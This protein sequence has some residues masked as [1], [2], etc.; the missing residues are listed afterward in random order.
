[1]HAVTDNIVFAQ[2]PVIV[3]QLAIAEWINLPDI[4]GHEDGVY[5][6]LVCIGVGISLV[7]DNLEGIGVLSLAQRYTIGRVAYGASRMTV[8]SP[9]FLCLTQM[10]GDSV[11]AACSKERERYLS[12]CGL[13][14]VNEIN[15]VFMGY[16]DGGFVGFLQWI[17]C[18]GIGKGGGC[19]E[20]LWLG[21]R[22]YL[23]VVVPYPHTPPIALSRL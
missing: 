5:T 10:E 14:E 19:A 16:A 6:T 23:S 11:L 2:Q 9:V 18:Y 22:A 4:G 8:H 15:V 17:A 3:F 1:M 12:E 7:R 21:I 20:C 13:S